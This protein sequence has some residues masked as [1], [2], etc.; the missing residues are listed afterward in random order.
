[1]KEKKNLTYFVKTFTIGTSI[2]TEIYWVCMNLGRKYVSYVELAVQM[3]PIQVF[4]S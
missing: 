1:M 3:A 2:Q 4:G